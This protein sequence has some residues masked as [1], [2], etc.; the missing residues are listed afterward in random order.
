MS[1][2]LKPLY[3]QIAET[4]QRMTELGYHASIEGDID[5]GSVSPA[6]LD[7]AREVI[8]YITAWL[9]DEEKM[10]Y[11]AGCPDFEDRPALIFIVEA[12]RLLNGQDHAKAARLL[13]AAT[14]DIESRTETVR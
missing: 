3:D 7:P 13:K 11:W 9:P 14:A 2:S 5:D 4:Y 12:A 1:T 6:L 10:S 8:D